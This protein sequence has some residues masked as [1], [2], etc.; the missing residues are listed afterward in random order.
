MG[1]FASRPSAPSFQLAAPAA[2]KPSVLPIIGAIIVVGLFFV[3]IFSA[4]NVASSMGAS[5]TSDLAP[6]EVDGK[7]GSTV[8]SSV[9]GSN[10]NLQFW[11]YIKDWEYKFGET[12][13]VIA[14]VSS[15]N[16]GVG[17]PRVTL[18][19]TDNALD[20]SVSVY[21]TDSTLQTTN[22]GSGSTY[23]VTVENVPLQSW[24][25]VSISIYGRNVDVYINGQLVKS[26]VLPG[27]TMPAS[28]SLVIGGGGGFAGAVCTVKNGSVKLEP[29]DASGFY[30]AG[31]VCSASTPSSTSQL[32]N[33]SL[34]GYTFVFG[35][36]DSTGKQVTGL[37][38]SDVSGAFS[39]SS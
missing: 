13:P 11:M 3:F 18:H 9:S 30:A 7:V 19:P 12:K 8:S 16:P 29:A 6:T 32:N 4:K 39:S 20:I 26:A 21:P 2:P 15:T 17:V 5:T 22:S 23:T 31:T 33:L 37:S 24:F 38:S 1:A 27:V 35:V 25:A 34:F 14:Q 10:T 28:G 36:K